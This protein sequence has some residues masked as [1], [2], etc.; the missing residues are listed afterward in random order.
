MIRYIAVF[1]ISLFLAIILMKVV[2]ASQEGDQS[3]VMVYKTEGEERIEI[4]K[5]KAGDLFGE[6]AFLNPPKATATMMK[7][8]NLIN[9]FD[10]P[11]GVH[12]V[13]HLR[14]VLRRGC[15]NGLTGSSDL[16]CFRSVHIKRIG[17]AE[18]HKE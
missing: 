18:I 14:Q 3:P 16:T 1:V 8:R 11:I 2:M 7:I 17:R 5:L 15:F 12:K 10:L 4:A 6:M 9:K 13:D